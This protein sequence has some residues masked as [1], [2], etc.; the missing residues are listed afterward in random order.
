V[1]LVPYLVF[2]R[3]QTA[4]GGSVIVMVLVLFGFGWVKTRLLKERNW[5]VCARNGVQMVVMGS[6]AAGA[7]MGCV[8]AVGG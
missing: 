6:L 8:K 1:P 2:E 3:M 7:A 4:F 5:E